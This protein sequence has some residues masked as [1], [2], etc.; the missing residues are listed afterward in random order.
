MTQTMDLIANK[1]KVRTYETRLQMGADAAKD[2]AEK[3]KE[4]CF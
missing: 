2:V 3:I 1:L 4:L